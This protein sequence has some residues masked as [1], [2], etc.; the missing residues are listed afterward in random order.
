MALSRLHRDT[1]SLIK[2][3][4][5]T[6]D[7]IKANVTSDV[8]FITYSGEL[9]ESGDL[10]QRQM[11]NGAFETYEVIDPGF[12]E[13]L[14]SRIPAHYQIKHKNLGLPEA[15]KAM[16]NITYNFSGHNARVNNDSVDNSTNIVETDSSII[17]HIDAL[18]QEVNRVV[19]SANEKQEALEI[20][21][22][23]EVQFESS[24]PSKAVLNSLFLALPQL[25][26]IASIGSYLIAALGS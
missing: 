16:Q 1:V 11:T 15:E 4:G 14:S 10:I 7:N 3:N 23:I 22:A 12:S 8:I 5:E 24:S 26:S 17:E 21:D 20:I 2:K 25:G 13:G 19:E 9:I 18:R 6:V